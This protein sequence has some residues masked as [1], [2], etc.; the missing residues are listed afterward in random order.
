MTHV[1]KSS[2]TFEWIKYRS[3][4]LRNYFCFHLRIKDQARILDLI[5]L[6][7]YV[8]TSGRACKVIAG[9]VCYISTILHSKLSKVRHKLPQSSSNNKMY[10]FHKPV[11]ILKDDI[12]RSRLINTLINLK[13]VARVHKFQLQL[14]SIK[15]VP[16]IFKKVSSSP[17]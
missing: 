16:F 11:K 14:K 7:K 3:D 10:S 4:K 5:K 6:C 13:C 12:Y 9:K 15:C 2:N 1:P 8:F 17:W